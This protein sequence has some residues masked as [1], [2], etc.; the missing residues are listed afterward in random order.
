MKYLNQA[1]LKVH[2]FGMKT[3]K[4]SL[5]SISKGL[6]PCHT[7]PHV[8]E[9]CR[10]DSKIGCL[11]MS[12]GCCFMSVGC[13][14]PSSPGL[15]AFF[16]FGERPGC[17]WHQFCKF[18]V[19]S[20]S[21]ACLLHLSSLCGA[22]SVLVFSC[23][24]CVRYLPGLSGLVCFV[25]WPVLNHPKLE[26]DYN[27]RDYLL[28]GSWL[29]V[30][31]QLYVCSVCLLVSYTC[32]T[33]PLSILMSSGFYVLSLQVMRY[34]CFWYQFWMTLMVMVGDSNWFVADAN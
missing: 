2:V 16:D 10:T 30:L 20:Q 33:C 22:L 29:C 19:C 5:Y 6:S 26:T 23:K 15:Q 25:C 8:Q 13:C 7:V 31:P 32:A 1:Q 14:S 12:V 21:Y 4:V 27:Q 9:G 18:P 24:L 11:F 3:I 28:P 34:V 17:V